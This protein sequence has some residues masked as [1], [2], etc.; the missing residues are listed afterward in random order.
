MKEKKRLILFI[1]TFFT[2]AFFCLVTSQS[3]SKLTAR[4]SHEMEQKKEHE[5]VTAWICFVDKGEGLEKKIEAAKESLSKRNYMRRLRNRKQSVIVDEYD[6]PVNKPY[7]DKIQEKVTRIRQVSRWL[8]AVS[9]EATNKQ[10]REIEKFPFVKKMD[11]VMICTR[12][13]NREPKIPADT[14]A[15]PADK[16]DHKL[17]YGFSLIQLEQLNIPEL[18][19]MGYSGAGI[20]ICM[21]DSGFNNLSHEALDQIDIVETWDFVNNDAEVF[22]EPDDMGEGNHGT[23]TLGAIGGYQPGKLIG[24]A[25]NASFLLGKTENDEWE[26]HIEEDWWVAGAEWAEEKGADIISSSLGYREGFTDGEEGYQWYDFDGETTVV[27]R[28]AAVAASKGI[29]VVVSSGNLGSASPPGNTIAAPADNESVVAVGGVFLH[30]LV[31]FNTAMGPTADGR[32]KPDVMAMS[33]RVYTASV[34]GNNYHYGVGTSMG[35]PLVAGAAALILEAHPDWNNWQIMDALKNTADNADSPDFT[36]GW[37]IVNALAAHSYQQKDLYPPLDFSFQVEANDYIFFTQYIDRLSWK[38]NPRNLNPIKYYRL[39]KKGDGGD[40]GDFELVTQ[41][42][43]Q[44]KGYEI[45]GLAKDD[46]FL[47]KITS[48]DESGQESDPNFAL[49]WRKK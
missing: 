22:E 48:V 44:V 27:S 13:E 1:I 7:I 45:R 26:R 2:V 29:L 36:Y 31:C 21:L 24:S 16:K 39:Y 37:G 40:S 43:S 15:H 34:T 3:R 18:H 35:C 17:D 20:L 11:K 28:G 23:S 47:Y 46:V 10:L 30:R 9:V 8:N 49:G 12:P 25:Y 38:S 32:I 14:P 5:P 41:L 33:V 4:L 19:D 42:D 6:V